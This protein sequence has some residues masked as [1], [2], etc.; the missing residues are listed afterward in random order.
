MPYIY[1]CMK[2]EL[3]SRKMS[4]G[5]RPEKAVPMF[6]LAISLAALAVPVAVA[7]SFPGWSSHGPGMLIWFSALIPAFLLAYYRGV[8][9]VA[10]ALVVG[11]V[12]IAATQLIVVALG[13]TEPD[14]S[15]LTGIALVLL[16]VAVGIGVFA[17]LLIREN[18]NA[19]AMALMDPQTKMPNRRHLEILLEREFA[20]AVRGH[21]LSVVVFGLDDFESVYDRHGHAAG[22]RT[23][24]AFAKVLQIDTRLENLSA[25]F[26]GEEFVC[27]LRDTDAEH[28]ARFAARVLAQMRQLELP[29]GRQTA[30]AGV[31]EYEPGMGSYE[32]LIGA[33]DRAL[34]QARE[35][36]RDRVSIAPKAGAANA[37]EPLPTPQAN[38][39]SPDSAP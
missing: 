1:L 19:F 27:S 7:L 26:G 18:R 30:S 22:D 38:R 6:A 25:R 2:S 23:L 21:K 35:E 14:W 31:A 4:D 33:A 5:S 17:E 37:A 39:R 28:A 15:F 32:L 8:R 24:E 29:W 11:M 3:V 12:V 20:A 34:S 36:G 9:G 16:M 10:V 13:I